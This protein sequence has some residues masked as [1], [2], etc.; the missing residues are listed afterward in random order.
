M[1]SPLLARRIKQRHFFPPPTFPQIF[2][3]PLSGERKNRQT[4]SKIGIIGC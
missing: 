2:S 3:P 1:L 4:L